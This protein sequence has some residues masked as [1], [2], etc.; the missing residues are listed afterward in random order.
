M[1]C[2]T[3]ESIDVLDHLCSRHS[4][5]AHTMS[6]KENHPKPIPSTYTLIASRPRHTV[7]SCKLYKCAASE[8]QRTG[9]APESAKVPQI[10]RSS[11]KTPVYVRQIFS[12]CAS[13]NWH[14]RSPCLWLWNYRLQDM[15]CQSSQILQGSF[16]FA[17]TTSCSCEG[18]K[19]SG[20][21]HH[22]RTAN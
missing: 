15:P 4:K 6:H 19:V 21:R 7:M 5:H 11:H 13:R 14:H 8:T 2:G 10:D 12:P 3:I 20:L 1:T 16:D 9:K 18:R 22:H 17:V